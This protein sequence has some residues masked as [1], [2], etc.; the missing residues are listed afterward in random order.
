[1]SYPTAFH[2]QTREAYMKSLSLKVIALLVA[3]VALSSGTVQE[4]TASAGKAKDHNGRG[5]DGGA[6]GM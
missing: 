1:M 2:K 4:L 5:K 6:T 3:L